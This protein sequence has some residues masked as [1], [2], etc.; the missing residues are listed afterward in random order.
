MTP[1]MLRDL[2][3]RQRFFEEAAERIDRPGVATGLAGH[4]SAATS[5]SSRRR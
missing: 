5:S 2:L 3:G 1:D 4:P